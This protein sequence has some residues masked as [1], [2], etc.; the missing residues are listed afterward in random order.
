ME[1]I[2]LRITIKNN[3][4]EEAKVKKLLDKILEKYDCP[5]ITDTVIVEKDAISKSHPVLTLGTSWSIGKKRIQYSQM[6]EEEAILRILE[7]FLHEQFHWF[8]LGCAEWRQGIEYLKGKY[9]DL[10]DNDD[11][12]NDIIFWVH[13]AV[14]WNTINR[15]RKVLTDDQAAFIYSGWRPYSKTEEFVRNHFGELKSDLEKFGIACEN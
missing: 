10:G 7:N 11:A 15:P 4:V 2:K 1:K 12:N 13:L 14:I 6:E 9:D 5:I 8:L 3:D